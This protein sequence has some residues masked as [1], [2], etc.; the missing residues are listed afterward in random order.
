M[1]GCVDHVRV[2][3]CECVA[4]GLFAYASVCYVEFERLVW[5]LTCCT[6]ILT[7][8]P[9]VCIQQEHIDVASRTTIENYIKLVS[10]RA[11]GELLT[12]ATWIRGYIRG[13]PAYQNNSV[14]SDEINYDLVRT[15]LGLVSWK[16]GL[17]VLCS[18]A[19]V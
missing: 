3:T 7:T 15:I 8:C 11:S 16:C 1:Q 17:L 6:A 14:V 13:H 4:V 2:H 12:P 5:G 19:F 10:M 9:H 18:C